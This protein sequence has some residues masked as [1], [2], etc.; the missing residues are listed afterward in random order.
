MTFDIRQEIFDGDGEYLEEQAIDYIDQLL[1]LFDAS[2]EGQA[3]AKEEPEASW[4]ALILDYTF[5]YVGVELPEIDADSLREVLFE[6]IPEKVVTEPQSAPDIVHEARAFWT[7]LK[8]E[9]GLSNADSCLALFNQ[10]DTIEQLRARLA[11]PAYFG[12]SKSIMMEGMRRGFDMGTQEGMQKWFMIHNQ[13]AAARMKNAP[14]APTQLPGLPAGQD[15]NFLD[16]LA[17]S[18]GRAKVDKKKKSKRKMAEA[19]RKKNRR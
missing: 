14:P 17:L 10:P 3:L 7:F 11:N 19:S 15:M 4:T 12:M 8:R 2:P 16:T 13:E 5:G 1:D 6:L 9:F 18:K